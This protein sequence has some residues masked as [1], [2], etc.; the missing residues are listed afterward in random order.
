MDDTRAGIVI[1]AHEHERARLSRE[2]H[3]DVGQRVA[4]LS[5]ELG[6]LREQLAAAPRHI[7]DQLSKVMARTQEIGAELHRFSH[8]LHPARLEQLGLQSSI[9]A[10]CDELSAARHIDIRFDVGGV[11]AA[12]DAD[13]EMCLYRITQEA[14]HNVV[15]HSRAKHARVAITFA[16]GEIVLRIADDGIGFD[17]DAVR[18]KVTLGLVNMQERARLLRGKLIVSSKPGEGTAI[19]V[20][21]PAT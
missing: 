9:R 13:A 12:I 11:P 16:A 2:L 20:R 6:V 19:E 5:A 14:L 3:D 21:L 18:D 1:D 15:K 17:P 4:L 7:Q 10:S 8:E